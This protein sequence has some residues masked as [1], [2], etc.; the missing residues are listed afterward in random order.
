MVM[1]L[2]ARLKRIEALSVVV[3]SAAPVAVLLL[4]AASFAILSAAGNGR[5]GTFG[6]PAR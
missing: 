6:P 5:P 1:R 3:A 2:V 4:A